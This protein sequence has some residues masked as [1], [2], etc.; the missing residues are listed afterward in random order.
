MMRVL[1]HLCVA[2]LLSVIETSFFASFHGIIRFTPFV[3]A[4]SV[5]LVQ[6][7][8]ITQASTWMVIHGIFLDM[9]HGTQ[10]PFVTIAYTLAALVSVQSAQRVFSNRSFYG[11]VTCSLLGYTSF[12]FSDLLLRIMALFTSNVPINGWTYIND[13]LDHYEMLIIFLIILFFVFKK[14]TASFDKT[15]FGT[16]ITSNPLTC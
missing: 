12:I 16:E 3:F 14:D 6:H 2:L 1:V 15:F 5:Y 7:H 4:V 10:T 11:V 8:G 13:V 9:L